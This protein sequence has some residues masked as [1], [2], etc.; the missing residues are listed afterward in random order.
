MVHKI[1][2]LPTATHLLQNPDVA[3]DYRLEFCGALWRLAVTLPAELE[4]LPLYSSL[5][6]TDYWNDPSFR[7]MFHGDNQVI[8]RVVGP[9]TSKRVEVAY[10]EPR[11]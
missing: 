2:L 4:A 6:G 9:R 11:G 3:G 8:F 1:D 5:M 7:C 10:M